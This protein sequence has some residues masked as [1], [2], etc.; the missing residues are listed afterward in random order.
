MMIDLLRLDLVC[1]K[2]L[3]F[4]NKPSLTLSIVTQ[5]SVTRCGPDEWSCLNDDCIPIS[6]KCDGASDCQGGEDELDCGSGERK[7]LI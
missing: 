1:L 2:R 6:A 3:A 4:S 5:F 7:S